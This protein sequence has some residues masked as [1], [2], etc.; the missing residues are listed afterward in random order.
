LLR[1]LLAAE[2]LGALVREVTRRALVLDDAAEL[3]RGRRLVEAEDLDRVARTGILQLLALVVVERADFPP[4]IA[5]DDR[6]AAT[7]RSALPGH[8]RGRTAADVKTGLDD[9]A[10]GLGRRVCA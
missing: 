2:P 7:Q 9:R 1:E 3:A 6:V 8:R 10:R 4:R 5:G